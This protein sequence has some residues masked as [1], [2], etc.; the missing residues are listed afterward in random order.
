[1]EEYIPPSRVRKGKEVEIWLFY[2]KSAQVVVRIRAKNI[3][4]RKFHEQ[5]FSISSWTYST[6]RRAGGEVYTS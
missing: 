5:S 3:L 1:M 6:E 2:E 4:S